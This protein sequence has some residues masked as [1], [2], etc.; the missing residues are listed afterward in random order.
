MPSTNQLLNASVQQFADAA[1]TGEPSGQNDSTPRT[2]DLSTPLL[3]FGT[4]QVHKQGP[5]A[6]KP[7]SSLVS[8]GDGLPAIPE[9]L[10]H[11]I[12]DGEYVDFSELPPAKGNKPRVLPAQL[13]GH[14]ILIP[15]Q[16]GT[17]DTK[18]LIADFP[19][20]A[21][22][23]AVYVAAMA[24]QHPQRVPNLMAYLFQTAKHAKKFKWPSWVIYDQN[25][26]QEMA[27]KQEWDWAKTDP[28]M[29]TQC[30]L[31]AMDTTQEGWCKFCQ[32]LDHGSSSCCLAPPQEKRQRLEGKSYQCRDY[33]SKKGCSRKDCKYKHTCRFCQ[34]RHPAHKCPTRRDTGTSS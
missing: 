28:S 8:I 15:L 9:R 20:W 30:F 34:S 25:F 26:R 24:A 29:Y 33:N 11:R 3:H 23:F 19:S 22:C 13:D 31:H 16:E 21:Q 6:V 7:G 5:A 27:A 4:P 12:G 18:K 2:S 10:F 1:Q 17:G 14:P 32:S